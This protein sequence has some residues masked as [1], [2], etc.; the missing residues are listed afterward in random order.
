MD[1]DSIDVM[2]SKQCL[3]WVFEIH[4]AAVYQASKKKRTKVK[5]KFNWFVGSRTKNHRQAKW[6]SAGHIVLKQRASKQA[7]KQ[8]CNL[9]KYCYN[10][11]CHYQCKRMKP[12]FIRTESYN[13]RVQINLVDSPINRKISSF[14]RSVFR[15]FLILDFTQSHPFA[16]Q[17]AW[18]LPFCSLIFAVIFKLINEINGFF[19]YKTSRINEGH[20]LGKLN[21]LHQTFCAF[22]AG[23]C[24][25]FLSINKIAKILIITFESFVD[26]GFYLVR[27]L[28]FGW[29]I[30]IGMESA[31]INI[32][33][34]FNGL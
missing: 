19:R 32:D 6:V 33:E 1:F 22:F 15:F 10:I 4:S 18:I 14:F 17:F 31:H 20:T 3:R 16:I 25:C 9:I 5:R 13:S 27:I 28:S 23:E 11:R 30:F 21:K 2:N 7:S 26:D 24:V 34:S 8:E 29:L 12:L